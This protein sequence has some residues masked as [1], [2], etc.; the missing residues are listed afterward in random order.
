[1]MAVVE[2][3]AG[4][5]TGAVAVEGRTEEVNMVRGPT[6]GAAMVMETITARGEG[7][8]TT[9]YFWTTKTPKLNPP[10]DFPDVRPR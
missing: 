10:S 2:A 1:M 8:E 5:E 7:T 9:R 3:G 4:A 6:M